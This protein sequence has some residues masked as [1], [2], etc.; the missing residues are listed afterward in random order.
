MKKTTQIKN[1][2][3]IINYTKRNLY[4]IILW[5]SIGLISIGCIT[6]IYLDRKALN[7]AHEEAYQTRRQY[8]YLWDK[9]MQFA[10]KNKDGKLSYYERA[11]FLSFMGY[12]GR[13]SEIVIPF[14]T[15]NNKPIQKRIGT[16]VSA[17]KL[18]IPKSRLE[19]YINSN[20]K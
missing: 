16:G 17:V 14:I 7:R 2:E 12:P 15:E 10:D 8:S 9:A 20:R 3:D 19:E 5:G 13:I 4:H 18:Y 1:I 6:G 11:Q